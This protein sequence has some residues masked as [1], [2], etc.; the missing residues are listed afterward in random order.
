M[1]NFHSYQCAVTVYKILERLPS[2]LSKSL[3]FVVRLIKFL[4]K[5]QANSFLPKKLQA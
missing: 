5:N 1:E 4:K 2:R 3:I